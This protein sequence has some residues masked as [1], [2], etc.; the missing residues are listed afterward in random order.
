MKNQQGQTIYELHYTP[1]WTHLLGAACDTQNGQAVVTQLKYKNPPSDRTVITYVTQHVATSGSP[2]VIV[3][4][5]S[6]TVRKVNYEQASGQVNT[7]PLT[8]NP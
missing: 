5:L 7:L 6:G 1:D 4:L 3:L 8:Y 2:S